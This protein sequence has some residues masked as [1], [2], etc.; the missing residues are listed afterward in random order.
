MING[1]IVSAMLPKSWEKS[2]NGGIFTPTKT[3]FFNECNDKRLCIKCKNQ[4]NE[5]WEFEP[6]LNLLKRKAPNRI[7]LLL[8]YYNL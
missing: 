3:R 2:F 8:P 6:D 5:N 1:K 4:V 7:G